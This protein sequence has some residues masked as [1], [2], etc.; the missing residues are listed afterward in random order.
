M[1]NTIFKKL[2]NLRG[3]KVRRLKQIGN[4]NEV[5]KLMIA[6]GKWLEKNNLEDDNIYNYEKFLA[7]N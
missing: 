2:I 4:Q 6:Y 3:G 5:I 1:F 7:E